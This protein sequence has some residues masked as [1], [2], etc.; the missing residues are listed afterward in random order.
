[1]S[2]ICQLLIYYNALQFGMQ[3]T[4]FST[5]TLIKV[6]KPSLMKLNAFKFTENYVFPGILCKCKF[7]ETQQNSQKMSQP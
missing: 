2:I 5:E 1:V 3:R 6:Q 7:H 4:T